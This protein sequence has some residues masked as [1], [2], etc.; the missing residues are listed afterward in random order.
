MALEA[1]DYYGW[2]EFELLQLFTLPYARTL[3][4]KLVYRVEGPIQSN[5]GQNRRYSLRFCVVDPLDPII[6]TEALGMV[7]VGE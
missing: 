2:M 5:G 3:F 6:K 7:F 1:W 4:P